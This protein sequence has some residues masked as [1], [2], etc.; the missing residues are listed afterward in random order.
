VLLA[1]GLLRHAV[2]LAVQAAEF[3]GSTSFPFPYPS[4]PLLLSKQVVLTAC[5][6]TCC[7]SGA[8]TAEPPEDPWGEEGGRR[9]D[10]RAAR[11]PPRGRL[12]LL[13]EQEA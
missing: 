4:P 2:H 8:V 5:R 9:A 1:H 12:S 3:R 13:A 11:A 6:G 10:G 7:S